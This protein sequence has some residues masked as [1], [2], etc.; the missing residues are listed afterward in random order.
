MN[1]FKPMK[2][3][4]NGFKIFIKNPFLFL[5]K[6]KRN[7]IIVKKNTS[8]KQDF[9]QDQLLTTQNTR[10]AK[11][12]YSIS[13]WWGRQKRNAGLSLALSYL[14]QN[15]NLEMIKMSSYRLSCKMETVFCRHLKSLRM[16]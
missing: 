2:F 15:N 3:I 4:K 14:I 6:E 9:L 11:G 8:G 5:N 12:R 13:I 10:Y 7:I 16:I 1:R